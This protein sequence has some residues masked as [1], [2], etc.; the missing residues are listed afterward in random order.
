MNNL[1]LF[2]FLIAFNFVHLFL[3]FLVIF[4]PIYSIVSPESFAEFL[5]FFL[6]LSV[7]SLSYIWIYL[8]TFK[9]VSRIS[10]LKEFCG[11]ISEEVFK[12]L[13]GEK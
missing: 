11:K 8:I 12:I 2:L 6:A 3:F 10:F 4:A 5:Y 7:G 9:K 13:G 1:K